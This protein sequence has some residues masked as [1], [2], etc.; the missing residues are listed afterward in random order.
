MV[1]SHALVAAASLA[2]QYC[3]TPAHH[4]RHPFP[5]PP[6]I[7]HSGQPL[8]WVIDPTF[9]QAFQ[10]TAPTPRYRHILS[11]V[12]Q[13]LV[14]PLNKVVRAVLVLGAE[15]ARCFEAQDLPL[16]PWRHVDALLTRVRRRRQL[17]S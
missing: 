13:L 4:S 2:V 14:A 5:S 8:E 15:L 3:A 6:L 10:V 7:K 11:A 12:P 9:A 1:E 17:G 16:P